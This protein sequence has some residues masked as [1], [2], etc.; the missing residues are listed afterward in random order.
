MSWWPLAIS[1]LL[2]REL[3]VSTCGQ[4]RRNISKSKLQGSFSHIRVAPGI[5]LILRYLDR[6]LVSKINSIEFITLTRS[7][8]FIVP[9]DSKN[10][11][12][13]ESKLRGLDHI[14]GGLP[15]QVF[16]DFGMFVNHVTRSFNLALL[17]DWDTWREKVANRPLRFMEGL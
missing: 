4:A 16:S 15:F 7:V 17:N 2:F 6:Q 8:T 14:H 10:L 13:I 11:F 5:P 9:F 12:F 1:R 3:L